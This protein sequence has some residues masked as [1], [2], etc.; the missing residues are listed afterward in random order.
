MPSCSSWLGEPRRR[1]RTRV[2]R[3]GRLLRAHHVWPTIEGEQD[4]IGNTPER[5]TKR[6]TNAAGYRLT[7]VRPASSGG[8]GGRDPSVFYPMGICMSESNAGTTT[9][10]DTVLLVGHCGPDA[11]MLRSMVQRVLPGAHVQVVNSAREL[12]HYAD[13]SRLWLVN[14]VLDGHFD[15]DGGVDLIERTVRSQQFGNAID[16]RRTDF[17]AAGMDASA[18]N[19]GIALMLISDYPDAQRAATE[20]GAFPGFGKS[21]VNSE[22]AR[23][24]LQQAFRNPEADA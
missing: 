7:P 10:R 17:A 5:A 3:V 14:R 16:A 9:T 11:W 21:A 23:E 1:G 8:A 22:R 4:R 24:R 12:Q 6:R 19:E 2:K 15:A 20:A 13:R 18:Q